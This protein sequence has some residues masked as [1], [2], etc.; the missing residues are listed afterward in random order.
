MATANVPESRWPW[1]YAYATEAYS[2]SPTPILQ[3]T[4]ADS[5]APPYELWHG[6]VPDFNRFHPF[7]CRAVIKRKGRT[8]STQPRGL[9]VI[10]IGLSNNA[11]TYRFGD[12]AWGTILHTAGAIF[13]EDDFSLSSLA[14]ESP[15]SPQPSSLRGDSVAGNFSDFDSDSEL[16]YSDS[17]SAS[18][19][20]TGS[21]TL[22]SSAS[23]ASSP[24]DSEASAASALSCDGPQSPLPP[25][26]PR[27]STQRWAPSLR[28]LET[29]SYSG[30][31]CARSHQGSRS[32]S[33]LTRGLKTSPRGH[34]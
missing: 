19:P 25:P 28:F 3:K 32:L 8:T 24:P 31:S 23:A 16:E 4:C 22:P 30:S 20:S 26:A 2:C 21:L 11:R 10:F 9:D 7:C 14:S 5:S 6:L 12:R 29:C 34:D 18:P 1:A 27:R 33:C 13:Y 17:N 15:F